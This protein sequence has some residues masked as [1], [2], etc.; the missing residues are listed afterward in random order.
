MRKLF[1]D[2]S[3]GEFLR[4]DGEWTRDLN[5]ACNF[6]RNDQAELQD[7][8]RGLRNVEWLYSFDDHITNAKYDF[9]IEI[10]PVRGLPKP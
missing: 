10:L 4:S 8:A 6:H 1:R 7:R 9:T 3:T 2:R 5:L